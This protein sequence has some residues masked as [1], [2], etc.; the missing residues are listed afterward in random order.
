AASWTAWANAMMNGLSEAGLAQQLILSPEYQATRADN[1]LYVASLYAD[2]LGR[3]ARGSEI[4]AWSRGLDH[5]RTR[6]GLAAFFL[7]SSEVNT[8]IVDNFYNNFLR[9]AADPAG[10]Q[11]FVGA[12][13]NHQLSMQAVAET[14]LSSDEYFAM[15]LHASQQV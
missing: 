10:E 11:A 6:A 8:H 3:V 1:S 14:I 12:L 4:S 9:R 7:T 13:N 15:A 2:V 5:G